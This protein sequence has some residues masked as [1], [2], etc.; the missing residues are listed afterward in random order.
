MSD[1][2]E[3][4]GREQKLLRHARRE[5]LLIMGVWA[6][7]LTWTVAYSYML[8]Y[9]RDPESVRLILGIPDW[10]FWSVVAPW[11]VCLLFT[12]WFCFGIMA[13]DDLGRDVDEGAGHG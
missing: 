12:I 5:G 9:G 10:V 8:G 2:R 6:V 11:G 7:A 13:D 1:L 3:A 4:G